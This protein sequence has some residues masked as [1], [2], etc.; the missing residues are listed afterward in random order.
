M[1]GAAAEPTLLPSPELQFVDPNGVPYAGGT[2]A[3]YVPGTTTPKDSWMDWGGTVLNANPIVLDS[4]G[5]CI[6]WGD[7]DYR[8]ILE[9]ADGNL[10]FDQNSTTL[11]SAAMVPVVSAPTLAAARDAM[12]ITAAIQVETDRAVAMEQYLLS[13]IN[14][15]SSALAAEIA[16]AE[17]AEAALQTAI[18]AETAR[19]MAAEAALGA[20]SIPSFRLGTATTADSGYVTVTYSSPF[21][22]GTSAV[23]CQGIGDNLDAWFNVFSATASGFQC[24]SATPRQ[25]TWI[26][27][28]AT[29]YYIALGY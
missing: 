20:A 13:L 18:N 5:R 7:G 19:A 24:S 29:F 8:C 27:G 14:S 3:L 1:S 25:Y 4:A 15:P 9:D 12:G 6:V 22:T 21:S 2:F 10:I 11:V 17:A 16:R 28:P 26:R 23:A